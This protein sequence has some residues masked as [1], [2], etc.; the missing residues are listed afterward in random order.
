M[1]AAAL[2]SLKPRPSDANKCA[3]ACLKFSNGK[4]CR[5]WSFCVD[6]AA[7]AGQCM[8]FPRPPPSQDPRQQKRPAATTTFTPSCTSGVRLTDAPAAKGARLCL[9]LRVVGGGNSGAGWCLP[10]EGAHVLL[11]VCGGEAAGRQGLGGSGNACAPLTQPNPPPPP[12]APSARAAA[13]GAAGAPAKPA[14]A[15]AAQP[16]RSSQ[17]K[18]TYVEGSEWR[19]P[20][21][22]KGL[23]CGPTP[24]SGG[25]THC[26]AAHSE[27]GSAALPTLLPLTAPRRPANR[28]HPAADDLSS[29]KAQ[30]ASVPTA[31][32][33][34]ALCGE[35]RGCKSWSWNVGGGKRCYLKHAA[36]GKDFKQAKGAWAGVMA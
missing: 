11:R 36:Q 27:W 26:R 30:G 32:A 18:H 29:A 1:A 31:T 8:L 19:R 17:L 3:T 2:I 12:F 6:E 21:R 13:G 34:C 14:P 35:T 22:G 4:K 9:R 25:R 16:C 23:Q 10:G 5:A 24:E 15:G 20:V 7:K 28:P 33:C